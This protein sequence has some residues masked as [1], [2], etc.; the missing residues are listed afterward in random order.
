M[1]LLE[2]YIKYSASSTAAADWFNESRQCFR[3]QLTPFHFLERVGKGKE[4]ESDHMK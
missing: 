3:K 4:R 2:L 1:R